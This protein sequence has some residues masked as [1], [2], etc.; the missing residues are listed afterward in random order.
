MSTVSP[1]F[2]FLKPMDPEVCHLL[3]SLYRIFNGKSLKTEIHITVRGPCYQPISQEYVNQLQDSIKQS[4]ILIHGIGMFRNPG[5]TVVFIKADSKELK[6]AMRKPDFP[7][8]HYRPVPHISLYRG[9]DLERAQAVS[10]FLERE[11]LGFV[12]HEFDLFVQEYKQ[13]ELPFVDEGR[14]VETGFQGLLDTG[15]VCPGILARAEKAMAAWAW[16]DSKPAAQV[17]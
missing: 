11:D 10:R 2:L 6:A 13:L 5:E 16:D 15:L 8:K 3:A 1:Q 14:S 7:K 4:P 12:C 9:S 17:S